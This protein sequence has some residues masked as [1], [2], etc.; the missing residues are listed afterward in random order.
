MSATTIDELEVTSEI[1][2]AVANAIEEWMDE[3]GADT[4]LSRTHRRRAIGLALLR[5]ASEQLV[6]VGDEDASVEAVHDCATACRAY[7]LKEFRRLRRG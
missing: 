1:H 7:F 6:Y 3:Y 2:S 4:N 5:C